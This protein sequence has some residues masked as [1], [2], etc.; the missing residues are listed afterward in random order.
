[1]NCFLEEQSCRRSE[2]KKRFFTDF[3]KI[4]PQKDRFLAVFSA[5]TD[6]QSKEHIILPG[7][8]LFDF[9]RISHR[10]GGKEGV[11]SRQFHFRSSVASTLV[12]V[13]T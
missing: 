9:C 6:D 12:H 7:V 2:Q 10:S 13:R 3:A 4:P 8:T 11:P 5:R 1:M